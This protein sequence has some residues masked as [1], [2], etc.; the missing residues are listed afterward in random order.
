MTESASLLNRQAIELASKGEYKEAIA[1]FKRALCMEK[2]NYLLWFNLGVTYRDAGDLIQAKE[3]LEK[4]YSIEQEDDEVIETLALI[5]FNLG[6]KEEALEYC[7]EGLSL[8]ERNAHLWNTLGV[9][10]FN[11]EKYDKACEAFE[12]AIT[13]N[14]YYYDALFNLR[15]T[16]EETGNQIGYYECAKQMKYI[17][18]QNNQNA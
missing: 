8:N 9:I 14:P 11:D 1:C 10:Y 16:Y 3:A 2:F 4:A 15:D 5:S 17:K 13:I 7:A 18:E 12:N 6:D